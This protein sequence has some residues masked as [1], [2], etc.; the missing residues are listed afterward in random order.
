MFFILQKEK[1]LDLEP[2]IVQG[3]L[4]QNRIMD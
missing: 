3:I 4:E 1:K 2:F